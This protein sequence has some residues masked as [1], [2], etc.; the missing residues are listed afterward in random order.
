MPLSVGGSRE[1]WLYFS[2]THR[3]LWCNEQGSR[4]ETQ[5][6]ADAVVAKVR[7]WRG[8]VVQVETKASRERPPLLY[9][10]TTLQ[11]ATN[12]RY[13]FPTAHTLDLAQALYE[14][15]VITYPRTSSRHLSVSV[16]RESYGDTSRPPGSARTSPLSTHDLSARAI[17]PHRPPHR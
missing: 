10:L 3:G 5:A 8:T 17:D 9:D 6:T 14:K 11:R 16:N 12:A 4:C 13:A 2:Y 1:K 7:G 15:K